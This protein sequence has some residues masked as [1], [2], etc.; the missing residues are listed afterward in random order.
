MAIQKEIRYGPCPQGLLLIEEGTKN[1]SCKSSLVT[2][3]IKDPM[4]STN[5]VARVIAVAKLH[6]LARELLHAG[7]AAK[8][9]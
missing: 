3:W 2:Q 9:K 8:N 1:N 6:S 5:L 4:L 7:D